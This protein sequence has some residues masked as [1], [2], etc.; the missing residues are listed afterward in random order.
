MLMLLILFFASGVALWYGRQYRQPGPSHDRTAQQAAASGRVAEAEQEWLQGAKEDPNYAPSYLHLG[1]LYLSEKRYGEAASAYQS[2]AKL[3]PQDG[4]LFLNLNRAE[5]AAGDVKAAEEASR[6]AADLRPD[7]PDALGLYGL[8]EVRQKNDPAALAPLSRAHQLRPDDRDYLVELVRIEIENVAFVQAE[9]DLAPYLQAHPSDGWACHLM[10]V[11]FELKSYDPANWKTALTYEQRAQA[12]LPND[13][14]VYMTLGD[15][16]FD[17]NRPADGLKAFQMGR[18]LLPNSEAMLHGLVKGYNRTGNRP[19]A[20][21]SAAA[22]QILAARHQKI[23][24]LQEQMS[25]NPANVAS[26]IALARLEEEVSDPATALNILGHLV[27]NAPQDPRP[28]QAL[29]DFYLRHQRPGLAKQ[30]L[31]LD[32]RP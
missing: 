23:T 26:G 28:H 19:A 9:Q 6:R 14:R 11:I 22:L 13:P 3:T 10:G 4:L 17:L 24:Y 16:Y 5:L 20:A 25:L 7:D 2:A 32:Y 30:A 1:D 31:R 12:L 29:S 27:Q 8:F 21:A 18:R 15:L